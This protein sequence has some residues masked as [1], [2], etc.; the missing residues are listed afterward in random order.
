MF[1]K[2]GGNAGIAKEPKF[3]GRLDALSGHIYDCS[4]RQADM[5]NKTTKEIAMYVG[6]TYKFGNDAK[7]AIEHLGTP[8]FA[9]PPDPAED[10]GRSDIRIWEKEI[11]D[12]VRRKNTF[13]ENMKSAFSVVW[14]QCSDA[15][16][17]KLEALDDYET[18]SI[19]ADV[20]E[21]L[22]NIKDIAFSF[23]SQKQKIHG[24]FD[25]KRRF[26]MQTQEKSMT[27]QMY[28]ERFKNQV[29]VIEHC[30]G[31]MVEDNLIN[32]YFEAGVDRLTATQAQLN[33][34]RKK[35][36]EAFL[37][38][39]FILLADRNRYAKLVEELEN[40][41]VKGNDHYPT[42]LTEAYNLLLH[43][44]HDPRNMMR[45]LGSGDDGVTFGQQGNAEDKGK[46]E[47]D[48][49]KITCFNCQEKGHYAN[50]CTNKPKDL[51]GEVHAQKDIDTSEQ[52]EDDYEMEDTVTSFTFCNTDNAEPSIGTCQLQGNKIPRTW[53]LLDN[54]ST[55]D[56]FVNPN[57]LQNI[58]TTDKTMVIRCNAGITKTNQQGY[59]RGYGNVWY[60]PDGIANILSLARVQ[61]KSRVTYDSND[62][63]RFIVHKQ[64]GTKRIF[65]R[66][67]SGLYYLDARTIETGITM[68]HTVQDIGSRFS[69]REYTNAQL[70]RKIQNTI[71]RPSNKTYINIVNQNLLKNCP[72]TEQDIINA[73]T[74]FGPNLGSLKGKT[75]RTMGVPVS[76]T[77]SMV[78]NSIIDVHKAVTLCADIMFINKLI[79]LVTVSRKLKFGTIEMIPN[80]KKETIIKGIKAVH[81]L[82]TK[83][84]F[85]VVL[86]LM[87]YEFEHLRPDFHELGIEL[88]TS[89]NDEHVPDIERYIRTVKE[90]TRSTY[91]MLPY[92]RIPAIMLSEL[93]QSSVYWLN[94]FPPTQGVS[95]TLSPRYIMTGF[96]IDYTKHCRLEFGAYAQVHE[97]HNNTMAT[98]TTGAIALRPTGNLQGGHYFMSLETGRRL[99]RNH[100][101]EIPMPKDVIDRVHTLARR[102]NA[103]KQLI[104]LDRE[105]RGPNEDDST[106]SDE[107]F[108]PNT[109][110]AENSDDDSVEGSDGEPENEIQNEPPADE[111]QNELPAEDDGGDE[112]QEQEIEPDNN[113]Q[114]DDEVE[115][116]ADN[117]SEDNNDDSYEEEDADINN[118]MDQ[119]YGARTGAYNLRARKPRDYGHLHTTLEHT[120]MT[121]F[122]VKKGIKEFGQAG[123]DAVLSEMKQ[124]DDRNV[125]VPCAQNTLTREE[126]FRSLQYLMF[127]KKK[128]CGRIKGRGCADGRKQR[129][130]KSKQ[131]TSAPTV[132]VESL[133]I[134]C[135]IDAKENRHVITSD[136]PGAFMQADMDE[137]LHMKLEG[138]LARLLVQVNPGKYQS[139][140]FGEKGKEI[141]YV[142][143]MK[144]LYGTL[145]AALL[146]WQDLSGNL[147]KWGFHL[148]PYDTCVANKVINRK[149]C[150]VLWHVD[151][152]K[153]SHESA[154]VAENILSLLNKQYGQEAPLVVTRGQIHEYL[155]MTIDYTEAGKCK[156][157]MSDY[158]EEMLDD[159]PKDMIG[160]ASTP[161]ADHLFH[162][163][164]NATT[165]DETAAQLFHHITAKLLFLSKR[166]R[167]DIQTAVAFLTTR[168]KGPDN[169]DYK[170][171]ARVMKYLNS[172]KKLT[173]VLEADDL[174]VVKWWVDGSYGVH[175]DMRSH[176]GGTMSLGKGSIYST[177]TRQK[178]TTK[179]STEAELVAV[180]DVMPQV[181][182][183]RY[184][185]EAQ[186]Y[187]VKTSTIYQD[188]QSA[189]LLEKN[190]KASSGK[191]TRHINIRYFF[192]ADRV[193]NKEVAVEYCP[194]GIMR[195]DFFTKP[196]QGSLFRQFRDEILNM[197]Q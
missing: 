130:Y 57:L 172:T 179:S 192:V 145:Q 31:T 75:P 171:L 127:L 182:W 164:N 59:L 32:D 47:K 113:E 11:D 136:V 153:I 139:F 108:D 54:G 15:I 166:A 21:L 110:I 46:K 53:I 186:G 55:V 104:F 112:E 8:I 45:G 79:F 135:A 83:R 114:N 93:V 169:D 194:T 20:L 99:N 116:V 73:E 196:L 144:A 88:N 86:G 195:G 197:Q 71:G 165:L 51:E 25:A 34:A 181:L 117:E 74:I 39:A 124:L 82:Y 151:D 94:N 158:I 174:T 22:R 170:K 40:D 142:Q 84:G 118:N 167:P 23:Q 176:T 87:D 98:R 147:V 111:F 189:I 18:F 19:D 146:F 24:L 41:Y 56:V 154:E 7:L 175:P 6:R 137:I 76:G 155:G 72:I 77:H 156:I 95:S 12:Y 168:V 10:A 61:E 70:A 38:M 58:H 65:E 9:I 178:L 122:S 50:K 143:L 4:Y 140:M 97:D 49:S 106:S 119:K 44:K 85:R 148:N 26:F 92:K 109:I 152:I 162:V 123:I 28:L 149:Q 81:S 102:S 36:K 101:T 103:Y 173:L 134:S 13:T 115:D 62:D 132:A 183:T 60:N 184:F 131:E 17:A 14:G 67:R 120:C 48:L 100:W 52:N 177:S 105:Q 157:R 43:W 42:D 90:R 5:Y 141:I 1:R 128:R 161:A 159:I 30:G 160:D 107:N 91:N 126:K 133:L 66:S 188:N 121:Q 27:C 163:D 138:P 80:R 150:T 193:A 63:G 89:S 185:L 68:I 69:A 125:I 3:E 16:K 64:D 78:P 129:M 35:A 187:A 190:G 191:R 33:V 37:S 2:T 180:A 29:E 96:N